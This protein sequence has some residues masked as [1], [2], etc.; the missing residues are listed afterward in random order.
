[1]RKDV[2][3][4]KVLCFRIYGDFGNFKPYYTTTSPIT[5][6]LMP[7][8]AIMGVIG[9]ILGLEKG[10]YNKI[11]Q[12]AETRV[13]IGIVN[14]IRKKNI[15]INLI[16]TKGDYWIPTSKNT[17]GPR[18]PTRYEFLI[19]PEYLVFVT[20][21]NVELLENLAVRIEQ[22][23]PCYSVSMG[24][25][26]LLA[27]FEPVIFGEATE[28]TNSQDFLIFS[29]AVPISCLDPEMGIGIVEGVRYCK[30]RFV[31]SFGEDRKP[32]DYVDAIFSVSPEKARFRTNTAYKLDDMIFQ[33]LT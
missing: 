33:F 6:S 25:A 28:I 11:L 18:T 2:L 17:S 3:Q 31:K 19:K 15:G 4:L 13:G 22:H 29:S 23:K 26:W 10:N 32:M 27:D 21:K 30:E 1:M 12:E 5:Y 9:A 16:N 8:T 24:L 7:P 20:M 14:P